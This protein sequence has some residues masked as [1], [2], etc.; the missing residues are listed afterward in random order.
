MSV[1]DDVVGQEQAVAQFRRAA[2]PEGSLA[3][4]WLIT[5]P[6][7]SGR[8]TAARAFAAT[9][10][11]EHG[12]G[13]GAC[14]SCR[15]VLANTHPDVTVVATDKLSISKDDVRALVLTAQRAPATGRHRVLVV[16]DADRMSA[17]TF[18][19]L[20]KSIE[21]PPPSTVWML[22]APSAEDLAPTIKSRCRLVSLSVPS[23][24]VV[25]EL[26]VRRDGVDPQL[27]ERSARAAQGHIGLAL[28]YATQAGALDAREESARTLLGLRGAGEAVMA[29][30][31]LVERATSEA[32]AHSDAVAEEEKAAF[33]RSAGIDDGK[34]PPSLRSQVKQLEDDAKRRQTRLVRDVLDRYLLDAHSVLRDVLTVQIGSGGELVNPGVEAEIRRA[35]GTGEGRITLGLLEAVQE[36]RARIAG[37]VPPLLAIE[38]LL[39]R[40]AVAQR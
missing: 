19:V 32:K 30:Q 31:A 28:R 21:E 4:A 29:A 1:W 6:P 35:A 39:A 16:E 20:L 10:Q 34:V 40:I 24:Q 23:S 17:G 18:N 36:A 2:S 12:T 33:L 22:C 13:C 27:A 9:L 7:G 5:G 14:R 11:C 15:M 37:N 26:L 38:A 3:Q 8:S 25:A